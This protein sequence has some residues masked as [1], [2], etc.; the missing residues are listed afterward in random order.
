MC[1][2]RIVLDQ[3]N[4]LSARA[5]D[6]FCTGWR[7]EKIPNFTRFVENLNI[8]QQF[9]VSIPQLGYSPYEHFAK[10]WQIESIEIVAMEFETV[11]FAGV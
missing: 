11:W 1:K 7:R 9:F 2:R 10:F 4:N 8:R 5:C 6:F 3:Q